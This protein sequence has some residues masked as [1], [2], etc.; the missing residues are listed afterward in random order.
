MFFSALYFCAVTV[1]AWQNWLYERLTAYERSGRK[2]LHPT[3]AYMEAWD[4]RL[5]HPHR[6]YPVLHVAGTNGKGS[7]S[8]YLASI[9]QAAGYRVGL[10]TSPH[11]WRFTERMRVDGHDPPTEWVDAF[12]T[13]WKDTIVELNLSFFEATVGMSLAYFAEAGVDI[14]VVEVGLGGRWDA[15]NVVVPEVALITPIGWDHVEI[16]GPTLRDIAREK[17]GIIK[18]GRPVVVSPAQ[19]PEALAVFQEEAQAR[20]APLHLAPDRGIR[21]TGWLAGEK[22]FYRLF[23]VEGQSEPLVSDLTGDYQAVNLA[24]VLQAVEVLRDQ[25]W[26]IPDEAVRAGILEAGR[27][28]PLYGRGQ[29]E[30]VGETWFLFDVA[31]NPPGFAALRRFLEQVPVP[32]SALL[33]GFSREK[34]IQ[35]A[36]Q[37]LGG[38]PGP[39][40]FA[41]AATPRALPAHELRRIAEPL[42]YHGEAFPSVEAAFHALL[43]AGQPALI[44]GSV[45][46]VAEALRALRT[47]PH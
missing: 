46:V 9:L 13:R 28:A 22:T 38:W 23:S 6:R 24:T 18:K 7:V 45:F 36:L 33:M 16:L 32:L 34:D 42:G 31:H 44:T 19:P 37:E 17:A 39:V 30:R 25:G 27:Q 8:A 35:G 41:A 15:T 47:L 43:G 10:H 21:P 4:E 11:L 1:E 26:R 40:F 2:A 29:W 20:Q 5:G 3:L 12:L 14:A